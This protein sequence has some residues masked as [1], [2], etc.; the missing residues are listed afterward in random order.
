M[1]IS[2]KKTQ[3]VIRELG[4]NLELNADLLFNSLI[5][6]TTKVIINE[7]VKERLEY[8]LPHFID[9]YNNTNLDSNSLKEERNEFIYEYA[10]LS[11]DLMGICGD[12]FEQFHNDNEIVMEKL[13]ERKT[14]L[15]SKNKLVVAV[16]LF[17]KYIDEEIRE[18]RVYGGNYYNIKSNSDNEYSVDI[19][20]NS[21]TKSYSDR[22]DD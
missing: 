10:T 18:I 13:K 21:V 5:S 19:S 12:S 11:R 15:I 22:Y 1:N 8:L 20:K 16:N 7:L 14:K 4:F 17:E 6:E 3:I 2:R 9:I